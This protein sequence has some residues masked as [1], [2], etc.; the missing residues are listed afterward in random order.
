MRSTFLFL[1]TFC[2]F[3][4][5]GIGAFGA[6]ALKA[7]LSTEALAIYHTGVDYQMWHSLGLLGIGLWQHQ[8]PDSKLV[9][10]AGWFMFM[11]I[12]LFS[13]SLYLLALLDIPKLGMITPIGGVCFLIAWLLVCLS[14]T[15]KKSTSRYQ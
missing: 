1:G 8:T 10:W 7:S 11:G 15:S 9:P 14:A 5:V 12:L 3:M 2:A 6:H 4:G 13:G